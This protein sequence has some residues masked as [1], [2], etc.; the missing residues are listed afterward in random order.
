M[1]LL[2]WGLTISMI[3]KVMLAVGVLIAHS[4][5]AHE[6]KIDQK[7][8]KSFRLEHT[9][10]IIGLILIVF[11][12]GLEIYFYDF[13]SMLDCFGSDCQMAAATLL[14]Q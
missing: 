5:L 13:V 3:G 2:F 14:A 11:G 4:E 7:V 10:T 9:L 12:Y 8:L 6:K 1:N